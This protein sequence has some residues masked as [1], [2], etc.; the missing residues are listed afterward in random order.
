MSWKGK[1]IFFHSLLLKYVSQY[2]NS[3]SSNQQGCS[4]PENIG[5]LA[6]YS[7]VKRL[8]FFITLK[9]TKGH[10]AMMLPFSS[11]CSCV[12]SASQ[13]NLL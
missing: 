6:S 13:W 4:K 7:D 10:Q 11:P 1:Q 8:L 2:G 5:C 12:I 9:R 3:F